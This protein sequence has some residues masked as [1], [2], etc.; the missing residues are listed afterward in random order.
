MSR[1]PR[2]VARG[3]R[4]GTKAK[5]ARA[6]EAAAAAAAGLTGGRTTEGVRLGSD[7][8][9]WRRLA[10]ADPITLEPL[11][12]LRHPPFMLQADLSLRH[13]T[14][15]DYFDGRTIATYLV[16]TGNFVHPVS[17]RALTLDEC[18]AL[19]AHLVKHKLAEAIVAYSYENRSEYLRPQPN[20]GIAQLREEATAVLHALFNNS[21]GRQ[22][23]AEGGSTA[24][25]A[26]AQLAQANATPAQPSQPMLPGFVPIINE[27]P[28]PPYKPSC[29]RPCLGCSRK[30]PSAMAG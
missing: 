30:R 7:K 28:Q 18:S 20:Q 11:R 4:S 15:G 1:L 29:R 2:R 17:R 16:S 8:Y 6:A 24:V 13:P 23:Q 5:E 19:D 14:D 9:W 21:R 22:Q 10:A 12:S 26:A 25:S 3:G 27:E